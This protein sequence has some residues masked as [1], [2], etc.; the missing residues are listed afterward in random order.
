[1]VRSPHNVQDVM[2]TFA[3]TQVRGQRLMAGTMAP[4]LSLAFAAFAVVNA[5]IDRFDN[6]LVSPSC[7]SLSLL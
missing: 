5:Y 2:M 6:V 4:F 3:P 1:M 7:L